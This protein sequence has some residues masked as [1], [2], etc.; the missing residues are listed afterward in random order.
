MADI[1]T[2]PQHLRH[3]NLIPIVPR[4]GVITLSGFG[5][6]VY[7]NRG[8]LILQEA[9]AAER[10]TARLPVSAMSYGAWL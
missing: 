2:V 9:I 3:C 4:Q 10:R 7:V 5:I 1:Q 6:K 8:H